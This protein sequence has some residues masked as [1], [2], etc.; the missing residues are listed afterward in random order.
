M[1]GSG[2][3][4]GLLILSAL[5]SLAGLVISSLVMWRM[6]QDR[7]REKGSARRALGQEW[8]R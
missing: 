5:M 4:S 1:E 7:R 2:A 6:M 8:D 3:A